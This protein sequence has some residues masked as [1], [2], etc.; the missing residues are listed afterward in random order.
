MLVLGSGGMFRELFIVADLTMSR[1]WVCLGMMLGPAVL[2][3]VWLARNP[4]PGAPITPESPSPS[5][6]SSASAG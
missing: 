2:Q 3:A 4:M 5:A 6:S 1:V